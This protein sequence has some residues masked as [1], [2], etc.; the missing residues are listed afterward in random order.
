MNPDLTSSSNDSSPCGLSPPYDHDHSGPNLTNGHCQTSD[1]TATS[2]EKKPEG[3]PCSVVDA[4]D[5]LL[6]QDTSFTVKIVAPNCD[7]FDLQVGWLS[8]YTTDY[9]S[10]VSQAG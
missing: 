9:L 1:D 3:I 6:I 7:P 2:E 4:E 8:R 5:I 10:S